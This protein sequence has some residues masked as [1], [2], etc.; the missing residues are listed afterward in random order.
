MAATTR[1]GRR[2]VPRPAA[3]ELAAA[4]PPTPGEPTAPAV[5]GARPLDNPM[6]AY[7]AGLSPNGA[8]AMRERLRAA[9]RLLGVPH[10]PDEHPEDAFA[11]GWHRLSAQEIAFIRQRLAADGVAP[12]TINL[13]LA[14]LRGVARA[15]HDLGLT[16]ATWYERIRRVK[17]VPAD[18]LRA[19]RAI[20]PAEVR[21]LAAGCADPDRPGDVRDRAILAVLR[22]GGL[23][24]AEVAGLR[25]DDLAWDAGQG[26]FTLRVRGK[27]NKRR[28]VPLNAAAAAALRP[29]LALRGDGAG[30]LFTGVDRWGHL[31]PDRRP[32]TPQAIY[33]LLTRR[34]ARAAVD[35]LSPHDFR[36]TFVGDLLERGV[37][38]PTVQRLAGH[39]DPGMT[40][41]YDRRGDATRAS[42]I[43][44]LDFPGQDEA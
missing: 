42:A 39:A 9:A 20:A 13:T 1:Q 19:G 38:L 29:W 10:A 2:P 30:A 28:A 32:L 40:A 14:A 27:G 41:R 26:R 44:T 34:V 31:D 16:D 7:L 17:R 18:D 23:R 25:R 33:R 8:R 24:R 3:V 21:R 35:P 5:D 11:D 4:P 37:D 12:A 22:V 15:A 36:R 43:D 6:R